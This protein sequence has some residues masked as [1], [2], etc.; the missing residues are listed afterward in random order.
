MITCMKRNRTRPLR[1]LAFST[2]VGKLHQ[3]KLKQPAATFCMVPLIIFRIQPGNPV[4]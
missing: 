1:D 4:V 3:Y 2:I